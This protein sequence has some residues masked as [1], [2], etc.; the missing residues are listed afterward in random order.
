MSATRVGSMQPA[1]RY[2]VIEEDA[3]KTFLLL[4]AV[5]SLAAGKFSTATSFNAVIKPDQ[6]RANSNV[7]G[8][9]N[10]RVENEAVRYNVR[11]VSLK[12][13][14]DIVLFA[15]SKSIKLYG[16]PASERDGLEAGGILTGTD[17]QG[18]SVE[19]LATAMEGGQARVIVFTTKQPDGSI[20]GKI[21]AVPDTEILP[22]PAPKTTA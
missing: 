15:G 11:L 21:V 20:S 4:A 19:Q 8:V 13:V 9:A 14:T 16:G 22:A 10:F 7:N 17:L 18:L 6:S 3:V 1:T 2:P 5:S 12:Q